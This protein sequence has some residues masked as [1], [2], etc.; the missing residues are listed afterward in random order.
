LLFQPQF[1]GEMKLRRASDTD[2]ASSTARSE[3][4]SQQSVTDAMRLGSAFFQFKC[5]MQHAHCQFHV[6]F[7]D[8]HRNL[9]FRGGDHLNID[10]F[11]GQG[12]EHLTGDTDV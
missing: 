1:K 8:N 5:F 7:I 6:F 11:L 3:Q 4:G 10:A 9:D 2:N 12:A